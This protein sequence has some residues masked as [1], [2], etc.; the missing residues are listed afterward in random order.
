MFLVLQRLRLHENICYLCQCFSYTIVDGQNAFD[1][2]CIWADKC[3]INK[4]L[5]SFYFKEIP[6]I[7]SINSIFGH[8]FSVLICFFIY[9]SPWFYSSHNVFWHV[10]SLNIL[11]YEGSSTECAY[12]S[13]FFPEHWSLLTNCG[14]YFPYY[15]LR[16]IKILVNYNVHNCSL[17]RTEKFSSRNCTIN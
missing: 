14:L 6:W 12:F 1:Y 13:H 10:V 16:K 5:C 17:V 7:I 8:F 9:F 15:S 3:V 4:V 2:Y 11:G